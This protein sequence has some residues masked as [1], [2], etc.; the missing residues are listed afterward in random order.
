VG[1]LSGGSPNL[2]KLIVSQ[3]SYFIASRLSL[4]SSSKVSFWGGCS[5]WR[6]PK[7]SQINVPLLGQVGMTK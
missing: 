3:T 1:N 5:S 7:F 4:L 6:T 2:V